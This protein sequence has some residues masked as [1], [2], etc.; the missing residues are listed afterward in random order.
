MDP[1]QIPAH[2]IEPLQK[3]VHLLQGAQ[4]IALITHVNADGDG[5]GSEAAVAAWLRTLGKTV[6]IT[7]PTIFP[8]N[9][10]YLIESSV[11]VDYTDGR[12]SSIIREAD[13]VLVLDTGEPKRTG[14]LMDDVVKR[15]I[16]VLDHHPASQT[17]FKGTV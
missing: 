6:H 3:L 2:R 8:E 5:A 7:N 17:G 14:R 1:A 16:A 12:A 10:R 4:R 11:V 9:Y 15:P 13:L